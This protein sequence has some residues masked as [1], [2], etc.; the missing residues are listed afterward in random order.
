MKRII[1][2][3]GVALAL[4]CSQTGAATLG[5][6]L[7]APNLTWTTG[8]TAAW[9]S[10]ST[11]THDGLWAAQSGAIG[12]SQE[13]W[14]ETTVPGPGPVSFWWKVSSE[15]GHD[16]MEFYINGLRQTG[17]SGEVDWQ[18]QNYTLGA[19]PQVLHWRYL[20]DGSASGGQDRGWVD[21]VIVPLHVGLGE[22]LNATNLTWTSGGTAAWFAEST[23]THDGLSA[24]QSGTISH[25]QET[26]LETAVLGPGSLSFWWKVSSELNFDYLEFY[27]N[28]VRQ[29]TRIAGEVDWQEQNYTLGPGFQTLRWRYMK[30]ESTTSGQDRGWVDQV[31][32]S[33]SG[34]P[35]ILA[36]P[37]SRTNNAGTAATFS[38]VAG[39]AAPLSFQWRKDGV[40]LVDGGKISGVRTAA[41]TRM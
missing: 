3:C 31:S 20:K 37:A 35:V 29:A 36:Q 39:G 2:L 6:A 18:V 4:A 1:A 41:L 26:W 12:N 5:E 40:P 25:N 9:V 24:A 19:G 13:T 11:T 23:T 15:S 8:G 16:S 32:F 22:A 33:P 21:Q 10:E 14:V 34:P 17:I 28:G 27:I 7:N 38:V 30:D